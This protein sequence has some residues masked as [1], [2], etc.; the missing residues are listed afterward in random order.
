MN[1]KDK[2]ALR[3]WEAYRKAIARSTDIDPDESQADKLARIER[4]K[5]DFVLFCKYYFPKYCSGE[6]AKFQK[7]AAKQIIDNDVIT[8]AIAWARDH[9]KSM[10]MDTMLTIYLVCTEKT[11]NVI[12]V[13]RNE[14]NA[15]ELLMPVMINL[16]A[17]QRLINDYGV[18]KSPN[19]WEIGN[20]KTLNGQSFRALGAGQS[21]RG[22]RNEEARPDLILVD[23]IDE[24][25]L[26]RNPKRLDDLWDWVMGALFPC[27]DIAG[28]K[29]F[30]FVGNIIA[31]DSVIQRSL[32]IA[33]FKQII[34]IL[35]E[36]GEPS[37]KEHFTL[38]Q[39][40][41]MIKK[42][43]YRLSQREYFNNP[44]SE[45]KV[46]KK[47]WFQFGHIPPLSVFSNLI[48]SY[49]DPGFKKTKTSDTKAL[50]L[51]GLHKGKYYVIKVFVAQ[52]SVNEMIDWCYAMDEYVT[53]K[54]GVAPLN[55]EEVFLQDLLYADFKA[56]ALIKKRPL[57]IKGDT[58][59]KPDK[60]ARIEATSGYYERG[61][62]LFNEQEENNHHM[63]ELVEQYLNFEP[64]V[65]TKKDGPDAVEGAIHLLNQKLSMGGHIQ[66]GQRTH[67]KHRI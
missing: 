9:A 66:T 27:F 63:Q 11:R 51:V 17:N 20:F 61:E 22:I 3:H 45:G 46:F 41:Y 60:D 35:S 26:C 57:A 54:N 33:D 1:K 44:I 67:S 4:L 7:D 42:L 52:A 16:E 6:F 48:L 5:G 19:R 47:A 38:E 43:G 31:K 62:V 25:E 34:N 65:R 55:M 15:Q 18:F 56:A 21:P 36:K 64:G 39:C 10:I 59:K 8:A 50:V 58:R 14:T 30:I 23:D 28:A 12:L 24:D 13:S 37:W 29:R 53:S 49:L 2:E 40:N 32:K